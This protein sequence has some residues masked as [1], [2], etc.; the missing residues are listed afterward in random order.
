[1]LYLGVISSVYAQPKQEIMMIN[2]DVHTQFDI[3]EQDM[4]FENKQY[5][6]F[7]A[8]PKQRVEKLSVLYLLDGNAHFPMALNLLNLTKKQPLVVGIG[9]VSD[10]AYDIKQRTRDYTYLAKGEQLELGGGAKDFFRFIQTT[11]KPYIEQNYQIDFEEQHFFG[12]SFGGLFGLYVLFNQ[13]DLFTN[14]TLAS[15]S[16]WCENAEIIPNQKPWIAQTPKAIHIVLGEYEEQPQNAPNA[17]PERI[18]KVQS[19]QSIYPARK[20]A[21]ELI[22]QNYPTQ[23][24]LIPKKDHGGV[25][26]DAIKIAVEELQK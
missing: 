4:D 14:Y 3:L 13:S 17:T 11:V 16:L 8:A 1:M 24:H 9:Y 6:L 25:I 19:R 23:F 26:S 2:A 15:P 21:E 10:K 20:L 18:G 7:I 12:H 5:R 22:E